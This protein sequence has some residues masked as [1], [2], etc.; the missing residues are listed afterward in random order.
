M[1]TYTDEITINEDGSGSL[2]IVQDGIT[3]DYPNCTWEI[4]G[5]DDEILYFY[6]NDEDNTEI[7]IASYDFKDVSDEP[8]IAR[9]VEGESDDE[10][11]IVYYNVRLP[12]CSIYQVITYNKEVARL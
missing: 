10:S 8:C 2:V 4:R 12:L 3:L 5:S 7:Y 11:F 9:L 1:V 6:L